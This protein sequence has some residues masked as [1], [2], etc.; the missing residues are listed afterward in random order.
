MNFGEK[1]FKLRKKSKIRF[2]ECK[3]QLK[4]ISLWLF[5]IFYA[6]YTIVKGLS[7]QLFGTTAPFHFDSILLLILLLCSVYNHYQSQSSYW[8]ILLYLY[9]E[10]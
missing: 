3:F 4:Y 5:V 7:H 8:Y 6:Y 9:H 2:I 1:I 10:K